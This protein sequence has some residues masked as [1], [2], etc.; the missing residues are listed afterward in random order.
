MIV[1]EKPAFSDTMFEAEYSTYLEMRLH[2]RSGE[3]YSCKV[4]KV[5]SLQKGGSSADPSDFV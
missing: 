3:N 4:Y 2:P 1:S 5:F